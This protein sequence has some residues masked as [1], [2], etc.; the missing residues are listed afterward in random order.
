VPSRSAFRGICKTGPEVFE[1]IDGA[2][3]ARAGMPSWTTAET[4]KAY[5]EA[6]LRMIAQHEEREALR[7]RLIEPKAVGRF[8]EGRPEVFGERVLQLVGEHTSRKAAAPDAV[9]SA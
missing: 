4:V 2:L 1:H 9:T 7:W 3:F 5:I 6:A 8:F